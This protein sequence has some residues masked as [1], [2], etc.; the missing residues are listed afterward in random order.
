MWSWA[1]RWWPVHR[2]SSGQRDSPSAR[3]PFGP[4]RRPSARLPFGPERRPSAR[5]LP[6]A[7]VRTPSGRRLPF[8]SG[9]S[10]L[11]ERKSSWAHRCEPG[12]NRSVHTWSAAHTLSQERRSSAERTSWTRGSAPQMPGPRTATPVRKRTGSLGQRTSDASSLIQ[13]PIMLEQS[14]ETGSRTQTLESLWIRPNLCDCHVATNKRS[15]NSLVLPAANTRKDVG[16]PG[17]GRTPSLL[18]TLCKQRARK[19]LLIRIGRK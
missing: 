7:P 14:Y 10:W 3:L 18:A 12:G 16:G 8:G 11:P 2:S 15:T 1:H 6:S 4:E 19:D 5:R 9:R 17:C 13:P